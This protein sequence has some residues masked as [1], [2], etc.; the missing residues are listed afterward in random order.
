MISFLF[1][2]LNGKDL[3]DR[4]VRLVEH[5]DVRV[6]M[7][8]ECGKSPQGLLDLLNGSSQGVWHYPESASARIK[9][10]TRFPP[11]TMKVVFE[12]SADRISIRRLIT[13]NSPE[14]LLAV[15]HFPSKVNWSHSDQLTQAFQIAQQ[16]RRIEA[17]Y[18]HERT[19]LTGDLNMNPFDEGMVA[20][21]AF[22]A[23]MTQEVASRETRT[24]LAENHP[25]FYNPMWGCLGDRTSGPPGTHYFGGSTQIVYFWNTFDQVL[26]RPALMSRMGR[27]EILTTDG[28]EVLL[29]GG[30]LPDAETGSD[31]LP[32]FFELDL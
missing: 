29:T 8:A 11:Q 22:H 27:L 31:H 4:V 10:L 15:L 9:V 25:F 18:G 24:V 14:I 16:I 3:E 2:N 20:A 30:G 19:L 5:L 1:W 17:D 28:V 7:L 6:L 13:P 32:L 21:N 23:V 12:D 26:L